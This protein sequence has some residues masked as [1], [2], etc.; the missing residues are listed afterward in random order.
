MAHIWIQDSQQ[1]ITQRADI[2]IYLRRYGIWYEHWDV[3]GRVDVNAE[4]EDILNAYA[5]EI[6]RLIQRGNYVTAD[7]INVSPSTPN[8]E[9]LLDKFNKEHTHD[10][11]EVRF[12]VKGRGIFHINPG[13]GDPVF[14][15][16]TEAGD[17]INVPR[18]TKHWFDLC[19]DR[20]I[21]CIR[22][23]SRRWV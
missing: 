5:P 12:V 20:C 18:G 4:A 9:A 13:N 17:L 21:R 11:D 7:V 1:Q 23:L 8:L 22:L 2:E 14:A 19:E 15:V 3:E 6:Q 16:Q 10:E